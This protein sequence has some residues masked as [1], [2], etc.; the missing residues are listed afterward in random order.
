M[1]LRTAVLLLVLACACAQRR[2]RIRPVQQRDLSG[3]VFLPFAASEVKGFYDANGRPCPPF[4]GEI[5]EYFS[6]WQSG[7]GETACDHDTFDDGLRP[8]SLELGWHGSVPADGAYDVISGGYAVGAWGRVKARA[9]YHGDYFA[10]AQVVLEVRSPHC[11]ADWSFQLALAKITGLD[12]R[13]AEFTGWVAIP[14]TRIAGCVHGDP[15]D[16]R[17]RLV[18]DANRGR[19]EVD[20]FGFSTAAASELNE[21]FGL[22]P[23]PAV[24]APVAA[25]H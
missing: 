3:V 22:K 14:D 17:L 15:I 23:A 7:D 10:Q 1:S 5:R 20:A 13:V 18:G 11:R 25:A 19:I 8:A 4:R 6:G 21:M 9:S 12:T 16:V 24:A 2:V